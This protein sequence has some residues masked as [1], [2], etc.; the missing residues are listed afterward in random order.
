LL[1]LQ[2]LLVALG[3]ASILLAIGIYFIP[4]V[5]ARYWLSF[6]LLWVVPGLA[7][8]MLLL[9]KAQPCLETCCV[10]LGLNFVLTPVSM[11]I[12]SYL[13][14]PVTRAQILLAMVALSGVPMLIVCARP[15]AFDRAAEGGFPTM[16]ADAPLTTWLWRHMWLLLILVGVAAALRWVNL[17]YSEFQGDEST[18]MIFAAR[19]LEGE[20]SAMFEHN[21]GPAELL[22]VAAGWRLTGVSNEWMARLPFS[23][24]NVL[25]IAVAFLIA[26][27]IASSSAGLF[28]VM[29][30]GIEG[31][32][33]ALGRIAQYQSLV[34]VLS[35]LAFLCLLE[36]LRSGWPILVV[37]AAAYLAAAGL[38]HYDAVLVLPSCLLI[39]AVRLWRD[40]RR[41]RVW[42]ITAAAGLLAIAVLAL[43]YWPSL[44]SHHYGD[45]SSY[46]SKRVGSSLRNNLAQIFVLSAVYDSIYLL[47]ILAMGVLAQTWRAWRRFG[48]FGVVAASG[49]IVW[50]VGVFASSVAGGSVAVTLAVVPFWILLI[51][52]LA[53]PNQSWGQRAL[54]L[55]LAVPASFYLFYVVTPYTHVHT[56]FLP[57]L[58]VTG[59]AIADL[60]E[61]LRGQARA[62]RR[63]ALAGGGLVY[64]VCG[65]YAIHMFVQHTPEYRRTFPEHKVP[66]YW[67]P[68]D[69]I[70]D[71]GLFGF[72]YRAGWKA[73]AQLIEAGELS[74]DYESNE[75]P[76]ITNYYLRAVP[77]W[78]CPTPSMYVTAVNVQDEIFIRWDQVEQAYRPAYFVTVGGEPKIAV[79]TI[80][81]VGEPEWVPAE[82]YGRHYDLG[83]TPDRVAQSDLWFSKMTEP[84]AEPL[85]LGDFYLGKEVRLVGYHLDAHE[86]TAGSY[87]ALTLVWDALA[88]DIPDYTVFTHLQGDGYLWGQLDGL[89]EC[90]ER[91]TASWE[92]GDR[93]VDPYRI[94]VRVDTPAGEY[95]LRVGMYDRT[96]MERVSV[97]SGDAGYLG[98]GVHLASIVVNVP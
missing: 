2:R 26:Q 79:H 75:E 42:L 91:P 59:S 1:R 77:R 84:K 10:S 69:E 67:T 47:G 18:V 66:I 64:A 33:L 20:S 30:L 34:L 95:P 97:Y 87:L 63:V 86:V 43:Y 80:D 51:G 90:G 54:W 48:R 85:T 93:I 50:G 88:S 65:Y 7:W 3:L 25:A 29:L 53:S 61:W 40:R 21:K 38:A 92:E 74:G 52:T 58:I 96:T 14:G 56:F 19:V 8:G 71:F 36:F 46:L 28:T 49:L 32:V 23:W 73:V 68:Y 39:L 98:D 57:A 4:W 78:H 82:A 9:R 72:P 22:T 37:V 76:P 12:L 17:G 27:R 13:P 81:A 35:M 16:Q 6:G 94:P 15:R 83:T 5:N 24:A 60:A 44:H 62:L 55:W 89:P 45:I 31:Y 41:G 11:L 70:P